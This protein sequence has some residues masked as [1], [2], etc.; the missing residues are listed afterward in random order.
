MILLRKTRKK[1]MNNHNEIK[2]LRD[3]VEKFVTERKWK[4]YHTPKALAIAISIES[5]ELLEHFLFKEDNYLPDDMVGIEDEMADIFIY[6][7]SLANTLDIKKF[8]E[9][10]E[11]KMQK[12]RKKYP[13]EKF[14]GDNYKKQ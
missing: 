4:K 5:A 3:I 2:K 12:N 10:I 9:I 8:F 11:R 7:M 1:L 14:S 6:L 13:I